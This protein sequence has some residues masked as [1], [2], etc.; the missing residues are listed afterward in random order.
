MPVGRSFG[1]CLVLCLSAVVACGGG[2]DGTPGGGTGGAAGGAGGSATGGGSTG[3]SAGSGAYGSSTCPVPEHD[4]S[5]TPGGPRVLFSDL[6]SGPHTGGEQ[7][8]GAF[9][10]LYGEGFGEA[11]GDSTVTVGGAEVGRY[12]TWGR[13]NTFARGLDRI[14]VQLGPAA[15]TGDIIVTVAGQASAG[16]PF[17]V[18]TGAIYFVDPDAPGASDANAGSAEAPF[19]T[20]WAPR[21]VMQAGDITYLRGVF[22]QLDPGAQG[23]DTHLFLSAANAQTGTSTAPIAYAGYPDDSPTIGSAAA[24]RGILLNQ[25]DGPLEHYVFA[26]LVFTRMGSALPLSG[27]GQR[28]VGSCFFDGGE[29][30]SGMIGVNGAASDIHVLGN[31]L[32]RNG[33]PQEKLH[34]AFYVGGFGVNTDIELAFDHIEGQEGGRAV[35]VFGHLAGDWVDG[36]S[37]HDNFLA[38]SELNNVTLGGSDAGDAPLLGD[39]EVY[40]NVIIGAGAEGLR[41]NDPGGNFTIRHNTLHANAGAQVRVDRAGVQH[42]LFDNDL[43]SAAAGQSYVTFDP[44]NADSSALSASHAL[45]FGNGPCDA[46]IQ[47]AVSGDPLFV[48]EADFGLGPGSPA[49]DAGITTPIARDHVGTVR[50]VGAGFDIGAFERAVE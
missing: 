5:S 46:W 43:L 7:D 8:L 17:A 1:G 41:I 14:V 38:A 21:G 12:V 33:A 28:V 16:L 26:N 45:C 19:A 31:L 49:I 40:N 4:W 22:D 24:R 42:I 20:L 15:T 32:V 6:T 44:A 39:V 30:D 27:V 48:G 25:D 13:N 18:R 47:N 50:P 34:H 29:D 2:D 11:R 10:T 23:W 35:Q 36:L 9:V 3:G 37:I